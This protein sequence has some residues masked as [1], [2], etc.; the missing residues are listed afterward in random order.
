MLGTAG[1]FR[2]LPIPRRRPTTF[3]LVAWLLI[4]VS[5]PSP[6]SNKFRLL[7]ITTGSVETS[8]D[9]FVSVLCPLKW[10]QVYS[11][12]DP[13]WNYQCS[14][15]GSLSVKW[16]VPFWCLKAVA[17]CHWNHSWVPCRNC[18]F[19]RTL[20]GIA[21]RYQFNILIFIILVG[22]PAARGMPHGTDVAGGGNIKSG[23]PIMWILL[24]T[25]CWIF[26]PFTGTILLKP[27]KCFPS[28]SSIIIKV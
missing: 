10:G 25:N 22:T 1:A 8:E 2:T 7:S 23:T 27:T 13:P 18:S 6:P 15:A 14:S 3:F 9:Q 12:G 4:L 19:H 16:L 26:L 21:A 17:I 28:W 24:L 11:A 20:V 5:F